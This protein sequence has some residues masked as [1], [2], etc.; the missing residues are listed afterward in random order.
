MCPETFK[1]ILFLILWLKEEIGSH[2][3]I[4][5]VSDFVF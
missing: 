2:C 5:L 1:T 4:Y 3:D